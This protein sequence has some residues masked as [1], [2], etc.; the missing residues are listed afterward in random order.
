MLLFKNS[1]TLEFEVSISNMLKGY[2]FAWILIKILLCLDFKSFFAWISY[3]SL[4]GLASGEPQVGE[5]LVK[6][7]F[8]KSSLHGFQYPS[9]LGFEILLCLDFSILLWISQVF[10]AWISIRLVTWGATNRD[11]LL[12]RKSRVWGCYKPR[13]V[14]KRDVLVLAVLYGICMGNTTKSCIFEIPEKS[15]KYFYTGLS[16]QITVCMI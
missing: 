15:F 5:P 4:L 2:L 1:E 16:V 9:V 11:M 7:G 14:T 3:A 13:H 12:Y 6:H 10:L 8:Q